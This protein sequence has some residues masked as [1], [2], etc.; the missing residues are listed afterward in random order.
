M[1][2]T[3]VAATILG[4][5][6]GCGADGEPAPPSQSTD[7]GY[8]VPEERRYEERWLP[9]D[10]IDFDTPDGTFVRAFLEA[11]TLT[12]YVGSRAASYPGFDAAL[13]PALAQ[14]KALDTEP[15]LRPRHPAFGAKYWR[16]ISVVNEPGTVRVVGCYSSP[17]MPPWP[18]TNPPSETGG[19][20]SGF[21][22]VY[23]RFGGKEPPTNQRGDRAVPYD[24]VFG[25][26]HAVEYDP[27][28]AE[29][30]R[31]SVTPCL[32]DAFDSNDTIEIGWPA[33]PQPI[34]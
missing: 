17:G 1:F 11:A 9:T 4:L 19:I 32:A 34:A 2:R 10:V 28:Y 24:S 3:V 22:L 25:S 6:A 18:E 12:T 29:T 30:N 21:L 16:L 14:G 7:F 20:V 31:D 27:L 5:L 13:A 26:W 15:H 33:G 8:Q 23:E